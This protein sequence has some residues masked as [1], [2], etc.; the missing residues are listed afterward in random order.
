MP[1]VHLALSFIDLVEGLAP[2]R[3]IL[4]RKTLSIEIDDTHNSM[5]DRLNAEMNSAEYVCTTADIWSANNKSCFGM[6]AHWMD[7][8]L[9]WKS[10]ALGW[11]QC[12]GF[13]ICEIL[14]DC[15]LI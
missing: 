2:G 3:T 8:D 1:C 9:T 13:L 11:R 15:T 12:E 7:D 4:T 5:I 6:T 14:C 10:V